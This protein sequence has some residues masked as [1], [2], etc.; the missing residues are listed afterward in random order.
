MRGEAFVLRD[1]GFTLVEIAVTLAIFA[2]VLSIAIPSVGA[3][4]ASSRAAA[5]AND[6]MVAVRAARGA[7]HVGMTGYG[8][9]RAQSQHRAHQSSSH[10]QLKVVAGQPGSSTSM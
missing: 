5:G 2:I 1:K 3:F 10:G 8:Y 6:L 9:R 4:I 7:K